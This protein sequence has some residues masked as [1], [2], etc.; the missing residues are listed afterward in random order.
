MVQEI[1]LDPEGIRLEH[2]KMH[3]MSHACF[4]KQPLALK[5]KFAVKNSIKD[6]ITERQIYNNSTRILQKNQLKPFIVFTKIR[7]VLANFLSRS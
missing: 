6:I 2:W 3:G 5:I 1:F 7:M 4:S